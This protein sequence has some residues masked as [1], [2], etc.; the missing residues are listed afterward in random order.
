MMMNPTLTCAHC[1]RDTRYDHT[2]V[3]QDGHLLT[4][5]WCGVRHVVHQ[6]STQQGLSGLETVIQTV[7]LRVLVNEAT[8]A[9][10]ACGVLYKIGDVVEKV[11]PRA[12]QEI[13]QF[14]IVA[15]IVVLLVG[16]FSASKMRR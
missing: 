10:P 5:A 3:A 7:A 16:I 2:Y 1:T 15:G 4:C 12:G 9:C 6:C 13:K 11:D 14:A 8:A